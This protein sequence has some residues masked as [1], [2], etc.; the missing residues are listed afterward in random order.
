[1][2]TASD[3]GAALGL[4]PTKSCEQLFLEKTWQVPRRSSDGNPA[5][6]HGIHYESDA[7]RRYEQRYGA[8]VITTFGCVSHGNDAVV[9]RDAADERYNWL[10]GSP[11]GI[12]E[13]GTLIE[14]KCPWRRDIDANHVPQQ[15]YIAQVQGLMEILNLEKCH[16]VQYRPARM[17]NE[18]AL[19]V[20][21]IVKRDRNWWREALPTFQLLWDKVVAYRE[22]LLRVSLSQS[23][24]LVYL[25][26]AERFEDIECATLA[27]FHAEALVRARTELGPAHRRRRRRRPRESPPESSRADLTDAADSAT[28]ICVL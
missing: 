28:D 10:G 20:V 14:V 7:I 24:M 17:I 11:D 1:M 12:T 3:F 6:T 2:L 23:R 16:F 8:R 22:S 25:V 27:K 5:M 9:S 13:D 19:L 15:H 21:T 26:R 18:E 4:D